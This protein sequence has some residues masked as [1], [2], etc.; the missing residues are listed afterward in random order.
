MNIGRIILFKDFAGIAGTWSWGMRGTIIGGEKGAMLPG[1]L[2]GMT[3]AL[4]SGSAFLSSHYYLL[5]GVGALAMY[6]GGNMT[7]ADTFNFSQ[8]PR[9]ASDKVK[10]MAGLL[11][12]GAIWFGLFGGYTSMYISIISGSFSTIQLVLFTVFLP[13]SALIFYYIFN[14][15]F[16]P[17]KGKYPRVYF[18]ETRPETWG[19]LFGML[20]ELLI[21][22]AAT[23]DYSTLAMTGG[24]MFFGGVGWIIARYVQIR[25]LFPNKKGKVFFGRANK[26]GLI[27]AW[28]T[29]ECIL[30][31]IA[32]IGIAVT[33]LLSNSLFEDKFLTLD[34]NGAA[35]IF[36]DGTTKILFF[37]YC[38]LLVLDSL[39]YLIVPH[40]NKKYQKK[41]L[42]NNLITKETYK[43]NIAEIKTEPGEKYLKY[44]KLCGKTEF[45]IYSTIPLMLVFFGCEEIAATASFVM[46]ML[47]L[48][49]EFAEK[50]LSSETD[51]TL[52]RLLVILP[53]F[54]LLGVQIHMDSAFKVRI[55]MILYTIFYEAAFF[56][57][58]KA[59]TNSKFAACEKTVHG[60]FIICCLTLNTLIVLC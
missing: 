26:N 42:K 6:C 40:E 57:F 60:F 5:A 19:G 24:A 45:A 37:V 46:I 13:V 52:L 41:L 59:D 43:K 2:L 10:G 1:A 22:S 44:K 34:A 39:Q 54:V 53:S 55:A 49:Q 9:P 20:L 7:Y 17:S 21:F 23:K 8:A 16:D 48:C 15:P 35:S 47:V 25:C 18:S 11:I 3:L 50:Y 32:F 56:L 38:I 12:K 14:K 36:S 27:D 28:K 33:F 58:K 31:A 30:G 29:M 4:F 51:S